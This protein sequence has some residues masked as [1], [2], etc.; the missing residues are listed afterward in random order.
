MAD[1]FS[2]SQLLVSSI[3]LFTTDPA[4]GNIFPTGIPTECTVTLHTSSMYCCCLFS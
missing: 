1:D 3:L 4:P 2:D